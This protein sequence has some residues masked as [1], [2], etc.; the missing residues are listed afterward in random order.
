MSN[1][2]KNVNHLHFLLTQDFSDLEIKESSN[3]SLGNYLLITIKENYTCKIVI[4]KEDLEKTSLN[5]SYY[6]DP[7]NENSTLVERVSNIESI[8]NDI[9][10]I[11]EKKRFDSDYLSSIK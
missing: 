2:K 10:D 1:L 9:K 5:W 3:K 7:T 11:F 4:K 8:P 6:S